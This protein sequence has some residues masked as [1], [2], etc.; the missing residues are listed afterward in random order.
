VVE[1]GSGK[2]AEMA[3]I[4]Q[5]L[6]DPT[7]AYA[8]FIVGCCAVMTELF[9]PG[10]V[11]PGVSG[12]VCLLLAFVG[13]LLLPTINLA[14]LALIV[15][16]LVLFALDVHFTAHGGLTAVGL[17]AFAAGS[18]TLYGLPGSHAPVAVPLPLIVG[19]TLAGAG[20][21][22]FVVRAALHTR[23]LP[24]VNGPQ[25]LLGQTGTVTTTLAPTGTVQVAGELWSARLCTPRSVR[26]LRAEPT[27]LDTLTSRRQDGALMAPPSVTLV[28]G[29]PVRVVGRRGLTLEVEPV[30]STGGRAVRTA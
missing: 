20:V 5:T 17:A 11:I 24:T 29:Q 16:A 8:L 2:E 19:L 13:F 30:A 23:H 7:L 28:P 12:G 10:A 25:R 14:S 9:H 27:A 1:R 3:L 15:A 21:S 4:L 6:A 18:L 22:T 26:A